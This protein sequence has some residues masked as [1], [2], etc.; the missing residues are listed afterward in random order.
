M[1]PPFLGFE[2]GDAEN[3]ENQRILADILRQSE[4]SPNEHI[5]VKRG[6]GRPEKI[7]SGTAGRSKKVYK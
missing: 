5:E 6:P 7:K 4:N 3:I 2:R 1:E